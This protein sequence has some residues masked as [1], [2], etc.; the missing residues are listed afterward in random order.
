MTSLSI[1]AMARQQQDWPTIV[2]AFSDKN[3]SVRR[4]LLSLATP[5]EGGLTSDRDLWLFILNSCRDPDRETRLAVASR[6]TREPIEDA[7]KLLA[8]LIMAEEDKETRVQLVQDLNTWYEKY[9]RTEAEPAVPNRILRDRV[10]YLAQAPNFPGFPEVALAVEALLPYRG[11]AITAICDYAKEIDLPEIFLNAQLVNLSL[12][13]AKLV[14]TDPDFLKTVANSESENL[15]MLAARTARA[16]PMPDWRL[17]ESMRDDKAERVRKIVRA[18][19][20]SR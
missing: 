5:L 17:L 10:L 6:L 12:A 15:R 9:Y 1:V 13:M 7:R 8:Y 19:L 20:E 2:R 11:E 18:Y 4:T 14:A 3:A 16:L